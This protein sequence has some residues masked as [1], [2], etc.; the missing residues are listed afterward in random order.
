MTSFAWPCI[1]ALGLCACSG[2]RASAPSAPS[3]VAPSAESTPAPSGSAPATSGAA[4]PADSAAAPKAPKTGGHYVISAPPHNLEVAADTGAR[5]TEFSLDGRNVFATPNDDAYSYG[6]TFWPSPQKPWGWP[7]PEEIDVGPYAGR[8]NG[9]VLEL[10]SAPSPRVG[11]RVTKTIRVDPATG[12]V[13][14]DYSMHNVKDVP[15]EVAPWE[16]AR[17][18]GGGLTFF[19]ID[20]KPAKPSTL[21]LEERDGIAWLEHTPA[22]FKKSGKVFA[23]GK[24]GWLAHCDGELVAIFEFENVPRNAQAPEEGEIEIYVDSKGKF[25][26]VEHQGRFSRIAPNQSTTWAV[27]WHLERVPEGTPIKPGSVALVAFVRKTLGKP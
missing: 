26:E 5:I 6:V 7:P 12:T 23:D 4:A 27:T 10:T 13:H 21:K 14:I 19:P 24:D 22:R 15:V 16:N 17:V 11:L 1:A 2:Q 25:V 20:G 8:Q 18:R 3:A 9:N